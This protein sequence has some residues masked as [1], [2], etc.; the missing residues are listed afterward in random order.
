MLSC[1]GCAVHDDGNFRPHNKQYLRESY[2]K[3]PVDPEFAAANPQAK[4]LCVLGGGRHGKVKLAQRISDGAWVAIKSQRID[5][6]NVW[7]ARRARGEEAMH[8][9]LDLPHVVRILDAAKTPKKRYII[10]ELGQRIDP[11]SIHSVAAAVDTMRQVLVGVRELHSVGVYHRDIKLANVLRVHGVIKITDFGKAVASSSVL[12]ATYAADDGDCACN[13]FY[14]M[15]LGVDAAL[16]A[17]FNIWWKGQPNLRVEDLQEAWLDGDWLER[18][19]A[20][21]PPEPEPEPEPVAPP[22]APVISRPTPVDPPKSLPPP[23]PVRPAPGAAK[24]AAAASPVPA[25]A[26]TWS[27]VTYPLRHGWQK[28]LAYLPLMMGPGTPRTWDPVAMGSDPQAGPKPL[29]P[30]SAPPGAARVGRRIP[31]ATRLPARAAG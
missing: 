30:P 29:A 11:D 23:K 31:A 22:P 14:T 9:A 25:R 28:S 20:P 27:S 1:M 8:R 26:S 18:L 19:G 6:L 17:Q 7:G 12:E 2:R 10:Q 13:M 24:P 3:V 16:A 15:L 4:D 21:P 5:G